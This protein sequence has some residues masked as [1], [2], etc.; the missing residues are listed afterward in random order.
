MISKDFF[1]ITKYDL[2]LGKR[3]VSK[4]AGEENPNFPRLGLSKKS[5]F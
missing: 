4:Q 3:M 5:H 1:P 2:A